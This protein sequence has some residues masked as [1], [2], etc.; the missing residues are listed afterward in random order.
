MFGLQP[1]IV[2]ISKDDAYDDNNNV[3]RSIYQVLVN[4]SQ[5]L[6]GIF[7]GRMFKIVGEKQLKSS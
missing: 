1:N 5:G 4:V 7:N 3:T 2:H 6:E